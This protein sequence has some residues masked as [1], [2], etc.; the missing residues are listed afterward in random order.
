M[1]EENRINVKVLGYN[2]AGEMIELQKGG[3]RFV[4]LA[5]DP[6]KNGFSVSC[7]TTDLEPFMERGRVLQKQNKTFKEIFETREKE[8]K[9]WHLKNA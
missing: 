7:Y 8:A 5:D 9:G 6:N 2:T 3:D 4:C 1:P